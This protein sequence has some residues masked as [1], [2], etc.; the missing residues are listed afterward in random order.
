MG[1]YP[2]PACYQRGGTR[3]TVTDA[4]VILGYIDPDHF[5]GGRMN[6]SRK[7][8]VDA[9][10]RQIAGPMGMTVEAAAAAIYQIVNARMADFIRMATVERGFD[11]RDFTMLAFG[12]C[13]PT[14][15]TGYGPDIGVRRLIVPQAATVF[16]AFGIGQ[17]DIRHSFVH[18]YPH[19]LSGRSPN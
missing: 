2:G 4:D 7:L 6:V 18:S 19:T 15:C 13:G 17:S 11:P 10:Q 1:A 5:L 12:G 9:I 8:A 16:S 3:P 14:H